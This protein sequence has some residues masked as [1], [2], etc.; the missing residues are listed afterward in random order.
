MVSTGSTDV[1]RRLDRRAARQTTWE[2]HPDVD[3]TDFA[4][5]DQ[6]F[7]GA[8]NA[9]DETGGRFTPIYASRVPRP[10]RSDAH[11]RRPDGHGHR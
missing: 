8:A 7:T 5:Y 2:K 10:P 1:G 4:V 6:A 3:P 11:Q 9:S